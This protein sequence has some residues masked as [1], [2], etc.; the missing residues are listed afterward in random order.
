[1]VVGCLELGFGDAV[2]RLSDA[3]DHHHLVMRANDVPV[4][5]LG[6]WVDG[7]AAVIIELLGTARVLNALPL[8]HI[9]V[10][11]PALDIRLDKTK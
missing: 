10:W 7:T 8:D 5:A 2:L 9:V 11:R 1:M 4:N 6:L 3:D